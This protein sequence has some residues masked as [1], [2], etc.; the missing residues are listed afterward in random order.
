MRAFV[1]NIKARKIVSGGS[2]LTM[3]LMRMSRKGKT[4]SLWQKSI[5]SA[6]A[7]RLELSYSK[8][9]I[10]K[11]Y[12]ANAP[13]GGNVVGLEAASWR[14]FGRNPF[15]L[16]WAESCTLAVLPNAPALIYP[17]KN[18]DK[19]REKRN[20]LLDKLFEKGIIDSETSAL[21]KAEPLPE[22]PKAIPALAPH[23]LDRV[24]QEGYR[25]KRIVSS[26]Q[27]SLQQ[28]VNRIVDEYHQAYIQNEIYNMA[29][30]L[31]D[32]KTGQVLAYIG[33]SP[34]KGEDGGGQVDI[35]TSARSS[36]SILK[37]FLYAL[38]L[39]NGSLLPNT[40]I[41]DI[42]TQI[43]G[44]APK[45]FDESYDGMVPAAEALARSL[46]I[47]AVR[48]LQSYGVE[49]FYA[50]LQTL[51]MQTIDR[52]PGH[53]GLSL[54]LGGAEVSLWDLGNAY[55][56]MAQVLNDED[57]PV[58]ASFFLNKANQKT[59]KVV[60][61]AGASWWTVQALSR[62]HRPWQESGWQEFQ[63][64][65]KIA[66]KT[67]TSF[68]QRDAWAIGFTPDYLVG[69]WVG[70]ADGEGRPG[71]TGV[72]MAAPVLFRVFDLLS[73]KRKFQK[74]EWD[75]YPA[76]ICM[77]SGYLASD[78][79][80]DTRIVNVPSNGLNTAVCPFHKRIHLDKEKKYRVNSNCYPV[81]E[82]QTETWFVLPPVPEKYYKR[83]NPFY[84]ILPP[85][86]SGCF[87]ASQQSMAV[88]YPK[89]FSRIFLPRTLGGKLEKAVFEIA[90]RQNQIRLYW[91]LDK[92]YLGSTQQ[93]HR[94]EIA[95]KPGMHTM[96]VVDDTGEMLEWNFEIL[97]R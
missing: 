35:I 18:H 21:A 3:Q 24:I 60:F 28:D 54:I 67:G 4:R 34:Y 20:R 58:K 12:A 71:L 77:E 52:P 27:K 40:L 80:P 39:Q 51:D 13:F 91:H 23:L 49:R 66:W 95:T 74:P 70:N 9:D 36:G 76:K 83:N 93:N 94:M 41:P 88:V 2:T 90:H 72:S 92:T 42:P 82:M 89:D 62:V 5:E 97:E 45:N 7:L 64:A 68:G 6:L 33:N 81:S 65:Q 43:A 32:V 16:S 14:Y 11:L 29:V 47:P 56:Q 44:F 75:L 8:A 46:N 59:K 15:Q 37:P 87:S 78:L 84:K 57:I 79:C 10:L 25:G 31:I 63:S 1:Q 85:F 50:D 19:L 55:L 22:K 53:Y 26:L 96:T 17:G 86:K 38:M 30:L 69:V 48:M 73:T 61:E